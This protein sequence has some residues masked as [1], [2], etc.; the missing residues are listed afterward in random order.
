MTGAQNK[1][2]EWLD[3]ERRKRTFNLGDFN[4]KVTPDLITVQGKDPATWGKDL[5]LSPSR[6]RASIATE[7]RTPL[8]IFYLVYAVYAYGFLM[9]FVTTG[10]SVLTQVSIFA[11]A[12]FL[13][14]MPLIFELSLPTKPFLIA[15]G[16]F[17]VVIFSLSEAQPFT[18]AFEAVEKS[19]GKGN[20][21]AFMIFASILPIL[22]RRMIGQM[23]IRYRL[24][25]DDGSSKLEITTENPSAV[26]LVDYLDHGPTPRRFLR[27]PF[28]FFTLSRKKMKICFYCR[29]LTLDE[30]NRCHRPICESHFEML[31]GYKVC[32]DCF[33]ER[34]G[35][36]R[37]NLR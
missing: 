13:M 7:S 27:L 2:L 1:H 26:A 24:K 34:R 25:L 18:T 35:K 9:F 36:I 8:Y 11:I 21:E 5:C 32:A 30:C 29:N 20:V 17:F 12:L 33:I 15:T 19:V 31:H 10:I 6:T 3:K 28:F 22:L 37:Y 23:M 16:A 4:V 14:F